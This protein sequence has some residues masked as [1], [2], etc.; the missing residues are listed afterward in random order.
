M[1]DT[2]K[3][4]DDSLNRMVLEGKA[5]DAMRRFYA[6]N[7]SMQENADPPTVG[8]AANLAREEQVFGMIEAFHGMQL[9]SQAVGDGVTVS[10]WL[11]DATYKGQPRRAS[12]QVAVRRWQDGKIVNERFYY[13]K[14]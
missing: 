4:L 14:A 8:L 9:L 3:T 11:I 7:V 6:D 10:E 12:Q 13:N 2:L 1:N 5:L